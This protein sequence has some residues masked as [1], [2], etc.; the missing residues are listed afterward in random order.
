MSKKISSMRVKTE[1]NAKI[2]EAVNTHKTRHAVY[3]TG[4]GIIGGF[5]AVGALAFKK[6]MIG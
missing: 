3:S 2:S 5:A 6:F 1:Q 4:G